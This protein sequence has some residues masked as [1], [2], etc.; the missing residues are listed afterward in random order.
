MAVPY[1][2]EWEDDRVKVSVIGSGKM[3]STLAEQ[4]GL[5][6]RTVRYVESSTTS[7]RGRTQRKLLDALGVP[8]EQAATV[9]L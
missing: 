4:A 2:N 8:P 5:S 1:R 7:P 6:E 9:F 3:G